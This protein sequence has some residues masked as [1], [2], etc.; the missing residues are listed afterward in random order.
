M[1]DLTPGFSSQLPLFLEALS[2]AY[3]P[4]SSLNRPHSANLL[5]LEQ[6][7]KS[8]SSTNIILKQPKI[9]PQNHH[10]LGDR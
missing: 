9:D 10:K 4:P 3:S 5:L 2:L 7:L 8:L 1:S 6:T